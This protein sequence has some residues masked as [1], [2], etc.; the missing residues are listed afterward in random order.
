MSVADLLNGI[1]P[2]PANSPLELRDYLHHIAVG[3]WHLLVGSDD[4]DART[5][6]DGYLNIIVEHDRFP[7]G[8]PRYARP[9]A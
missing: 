9:S 7:P 8:T 5:Y 6:L 2:V 4:T 1:A 3:G